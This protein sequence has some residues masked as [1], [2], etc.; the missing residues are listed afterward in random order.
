MR[1]TYLYVFSHVPPFAPY[2]RIGVAHG[3][4]LGYV[5]GFPAPERF[6]MLENPLRAYRDIRMADLIQTYWTNFA[7]TGD[8]N[9]RGAPVW[10]SFDSREHVLDMADTVRA[11]ELPL[12]REYELMDRYVGSLTGR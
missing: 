11:V 6:F 7:K 9:G 2:T 12:R 10:P 3:A 4:E 5:F 1:K 8:P